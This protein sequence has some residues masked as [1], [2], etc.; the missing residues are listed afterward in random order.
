MTPSN[1]NLRGFLLVFLSVI[2]SKSITE[3][4]SILF[5]FEPRSLMGFVVCK[6]ISLAILSFACLNCFIVLSK[7]TSA[8]D[9]KEVCVCLNELG[10]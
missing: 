9:D 3:S 5:L 6:Y 8:S 10:L 2:Y 4:A 7:L 1:L